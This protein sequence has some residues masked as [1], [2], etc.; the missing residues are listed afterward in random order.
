MGGSLNLEEG[1]F[2]YYVF[3]KKLEIYL[4]GGKNK[5]DNTKVKEG[6]LLNPNFVSTWKKGINY[7]NIEIFLR[8]SGIKTSYKL[9]GDQK[10]KIYEFIRN[11]IYQQHSFTRTSSFQANKNDFLVISE[12][13][14]N[15][16]YLEGIV[17]KKIFESLIGRASANKER[18]YYIFKSQMLILFFPDYFIIK[19]LISD[20]SPYSTEKKIVNLTYVFFSIPHYDKYVKIFTECSSS[21]IIDSI[22][23]RGILEQYQIDYTSNNKVVFRVFNEEQYINNIKSIIKAPQEINF[24]L[25]I[26]RVSC[27]GLDNVGATC[28]MNATL[29][30]LAN[31][32]PITESLLKP[33]KYFEMYN[34]QDLCR[35]TLEYCQVLIGLFCDNSPIG[36]YRPEQF[37]TTIGELNSLFQGVQANDSKDLII[38]LLE[39]LNSELVKLYNKTHNIIEK[40]NEFNPNIDPTNVAM[41]FYEFK[42]EFTKNYHSAVGFNLCGFQKN[43]FKCQICNAVSNSFSIFNFLM[44]GLESI[45]NHFN[46]SNNNMQIPYIKFEHCFQYLKKT[47]NFDQTYCQKC[48]KTGMSVYQEGIYMMPNYLIIILNRGRG[49]VFKCRVDIPEQFNS[50]NFEEAQKNNYIFDLIGVVSHFGESGMGGHFIAF[51]KHYL[52]SKWR[53]YNDNTV[54]EC[55]NDYLTKGIPYILFYK[56]SSVNSNQNNQN[57]IQNNFNNQ[58]QIFNLNFQQINNNMNF[59]NQ[60][61]QPIMNMNMNSANNLKPNMFMNNNIQQMNNMNK[62]GGLNGSYNQHMNMNLNLNSQGSQNNFNNNM[63]MNMVRNQNMMNNN[64]PQMNNMNKKGGLKGSY[65]QHMNMNMNLNLNNQGSQNNIN[66]MNMNMWNNQNMMNNNM[67]FLPNR[68]NMNMNPNM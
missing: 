11:N 26:Q 57:I 48:K 28:Y 38:F 18:I 61:Q 54:V 25:A 29:Q 1:I 5:K 49:N 24:N 68:M 41:V 19:I 55:Q 45:S 47:E 30:C 44:F 6:Y 27:R 4:N 21:Q 12:K 40:E 46:L 2:H 7:K 35:L 58:N 64:M 52:D 39:T 10:T 65:N 59:M 53:C 43:V 13:I 34:N 9:K 51:C 60:A 36:S 32:R 50:S 15:K 42:N 23:E 63:N 33:K 66:N 56:N 17:S 37:K 20:L 67:Q 62:K 14:I 3:Q 22:I 16:K 8:N 31:I